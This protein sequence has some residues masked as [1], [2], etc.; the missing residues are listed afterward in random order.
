MRFRFPGSLINMQRQWYLCSSALVLVVFP[1]LMHCI[2]SGDYRL[3]IC[4]N[5]PVKVGEITSFRAEVVLEP[6][7]RTRHGKNEKT[8][9]EFSWKIASKPWVKHQMTTHRWDNFHWRWT[10]AGDK[11]VF[12]YVRILNDNGHDSTYGQRFYNSYY[13]SNRTQVTVTE[14]E[15]KF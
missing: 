10:E 3:L 5:G 11:T 2:H 4:K 1:A 8:T 9:F 7:A 12:V 6:K 15:G 14:S 13:A